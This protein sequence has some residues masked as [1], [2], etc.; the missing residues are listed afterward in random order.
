MKL[1]QGNDGAANGRVRFVFDP[2][3][4]WGVSLPLALTKGARTWLSGWQTFVAV[5]FVWVTV[6][7]ANPVAEPP[8]L[9]KAWERCLIS[10]GEKSST[11]SCAVGYKSFEYVNEP[12]H[13]SVPV[14]LPASLAG[15]EAKARMAAKARLEVGGMVYDQGT[16]EFSKDPLLPSGTVKATIRFVLKRV[17][18]KSFGMV[19]T[20]EQPTING[21]VFYLP[22]FENGKSPADFAEFSI[23]VFPNNGGLLSLESKHAQEAT[24]FATRITVKP[25]HNEIIRIGYT[26]SEGTPPGAGST[27]N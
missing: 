27:K 24:A 12:F 3:V 9:E 15:D 6:A 25:V 20:Y 23:S 26:R 1:R 14:I 13:V 17:P 11:V 18:G 5:F 8:V 21:K 19:V 7:N 10:A 4:R 22:Q 16:I 2:E